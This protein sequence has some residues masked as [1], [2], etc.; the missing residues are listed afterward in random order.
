M[1]RLLASLALLAATFAANAQKQIITADPGTK[2]LS[3]PTGVPAANSLQTFTGTRTNTAL[4]R[5]DGSGNVKSSAV[6]VADDGTVTVG[7]AGA[8]RIVLSDTDG[9]NS[10]T[11]AA[12]SATT[13]NGFYTLPVAPQTG[14][15]YSTLSGATNGPISILN[16]V[17]KIMFLSS[18]GVPV[19]RALGSNLS[20]DGTSINAATGSGGTGATNILVNGNNIIQANLTNNYAY[21]FNVSGSNVRVIPTAPVTLTDAATIAVDASLS[22]SFVVTLGGNR[23]LGNPTN[24]THFQSIKL[25]V[26]QNATG[27]HTLT[28]D[29]AYAGS[30]VVTLPSGD[31]GVATNANART[32][33]YMTYTTN[34]AKWDV[35]SVNPGF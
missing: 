12:A 4:A 5:F 29:T 16:G 22:S 9:S 14:Y 17:S 3:Q 8:G 11:I 31:F 33:L 34:A 30:T 23:T 20:D 35:L 21:T 25:L 7:G 10:A 27:G 26:I 15:W 28:A 1:K 19:T 18:G 24:P 13:T 6:T 2:V 32:W